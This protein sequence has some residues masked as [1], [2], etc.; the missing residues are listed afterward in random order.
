LPES[1]N[2]FSVALSSL[3]VGNTLITGSELHWS[4]TSE[5]C[6]Q[7]WV[8]IHYPED[9]GLNWA[10]ITPLSIASGQ[11]TIQLNGSDFHRGYHSG[12]LRLRNDLD[13]FPWGFPDWP[14]R[15]QFRQK[16]NRAAD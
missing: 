10:S 4:D 3:G 16:L 1:R 7:V 15:T 2:V 5:S 11:F 12:A 6:A 13:Q 8:Y 14:E 9:E